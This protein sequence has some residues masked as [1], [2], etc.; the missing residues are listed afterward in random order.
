MKRVQLNINLHF[1]RNTY[2]F[3]YEVMFIHNISISVPAKV[4]VFPHYSYLFPLVGLLWI[5][6]CFLPQFNL[7]ATHSWVS[8]IPLDL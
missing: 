8:L 1:S 7:E 5:N 6:K 2:P 4:N 3:V